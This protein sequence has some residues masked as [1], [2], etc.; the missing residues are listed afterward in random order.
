MDDKKQRLFYRFLTGLCKINPIEFYGVA[1]MLQ[2]NVTDLQNDTEKLL[3]EVIDAFI[4]LRY[5][6]QKA[7]VNVLER[8][9]KEQDMEPPR[10]REEE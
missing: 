9:I 1:E 5:S 6:M 4:Q 8:A 7:I 3:S 10:K 2:V